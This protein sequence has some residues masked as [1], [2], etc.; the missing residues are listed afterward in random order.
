MNQRSKFLC[1]SSHVFR[2][3]KTKLDPLLDV[4]MVLDDAVLAGAVVLVVFGY[5]VVLEKL[6]LPAFLCYRLQARALS[7][8]VNV[9]CSVFHSVAD[10]GR[11]ESYQTY[12]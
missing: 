1:S 6:I 2:F 4:S 3:T 7:R 10:N 8:W 9:D 12:V 11:K 5:S